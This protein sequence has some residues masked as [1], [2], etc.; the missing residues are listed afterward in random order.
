MF[1]S[2][3]LIRLIMLVNAKKSFTIGELANELGV[4]Q[5]TISRDLIEL[6]E[7]GIPIYS[8][9]GRGGGFKLLKERLLPSIAFTESEATALFFACQSLQY[10]G[11]VPFGEGA[12]S[13]LDKF[14]HYLPPDVKEQINRLTH[15]IAIWTP[16]RIMS[17]EFLEVLLQAIMVRSAV[18][19]IYDS[20]Q[21][22]TQRDIQP[23][24]LYSDQGYWYCPAYC[25]ARKAYRLFRADRIRSA[26]LNESVLC[27]DEVDQKSVLH[28]ENEEEE[29]GPK[30]HLVVRLT[31]AGVKKAESNSRFRPFI[32]CADDGSGM[33]RMSI[34]SR[35][36]AF[37]MDMIWLLEEGAVVLE[38]PEARDEIQRRITCML[39]QYQAE[40]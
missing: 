40:E 36:L 13:A 31:P 21:E 27:L 38:P 28:W 19:I 1:K 23:V 37:Y 16:H 12:A 4:S 24:G 11:S 35:Q 2:Q 9:Q 30:V 22:E 39:R 14:Y 25:F 29:Q 15:K 20:G 18:T 6:G 26:V 17:A 7:L 33:I 34:P 8:I 10:F 3:R 32:E 5:R